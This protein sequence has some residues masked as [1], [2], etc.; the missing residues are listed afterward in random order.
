M[1]HHANRLGRNTAE[2]RKS[3]VIPSKNK[4][5]PL[6]SATRKVILKGKDSDSFLMAKKI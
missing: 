5:S 2:T 3:N 4:A 6:R 1:I